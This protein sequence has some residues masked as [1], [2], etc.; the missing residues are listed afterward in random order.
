[1]RRYEFTTH[2]GKTLSVAE[3]R[4]E[5]A[6]RGHGADLSRNGRAR[7][8]IRR[9]RFDAGG[10]GVPRVCGRSPRARG[11]RSGDAGIC[12]RRYVRG[13]P[14]RSRR[15]VQK[16]QDGL[17]CAPAGV[18]RTQLRIVSDA[19]IYRAIQRLSLGRRHRRKLYDEGSIRRRRAVFRAV[20]LCVPG[21]RPPRR[22]SS[23]K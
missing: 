13:Y 2:D 6:L 1:M 22:A 3:W 10:T 18:V 15:A 11:D 17:S 12:A 5:G 23:R 19:G 7:R 9:V 16:I 14:Q 4:G 21:R 20:G 8:Q